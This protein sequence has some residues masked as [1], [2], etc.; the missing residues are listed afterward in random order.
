L[1]TESQ[2]STS[3]NVT[4]INVCG[5]L[6]ATV[7]QESC[8]R[9]MTSVKADNARLFILDPPYGIFSGVDWDTSP[10]SEQDF[11]ITVST[12]TAMAHA[13]ERITIACLC[14]LDMV[15]M[16]KKVMGVHCGIVQQLYWSKTNQFC[17]GTPHGGFTNTMEHIIV[18]FTGAKQVNTVV[19]ES[20][21]ISWSETELRGN[22]LTF[23]PAVSKYKTQG[24]EGA[25]RAANPAQKPLFLLCW[26]IQHFSEE[27][28]VVVDMFAGTVSHIYIFFVSFTGLCAILIVKPYI[29]VFV[30]GWRL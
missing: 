30:W 4:T 8:T 18:G 10:I 15:P 1:D 27:R 3:E 23:R 22:C 20:G 13:S 26:L 25:G 17:P 5:D 21:Y 14:S 24:T 12:C 6:C 19:L 2:T 29:S 9:R 16:I 28:D 11:N 7:I